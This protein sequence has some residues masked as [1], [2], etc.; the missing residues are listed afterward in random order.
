MADS[1][2]SSAGGAVTPFMAQYLAAKADHPDALLFF[3][4]GDFYEMFFEDARK[5]AAALSITLTKRGQHN[6]DDIPMAG[7]PVHAA[8]GYLA[9]L[10]RAGFRV[11]VCEQLE[12]PAEA[13]KRGG[14]AIVKRAVVRVVTPGTVTED[15]LLDARRANCLAAAIINDGEAALAWAEVS[16]GAFCVL[17]TSAARIEEEIA[18]LGPAELLCVDT[19]AQRFGDVASAVTP[20]PRV[21]A[22]S[23]S[24]ERRLKGLFEVRTLEAFGEFAPIEL[25]ALGLILDYVELTQAGL[26]PRLEPPR[27]FAAQAY[28]AIDPATR[29]SLEI[30]RTQRGEREGSLIAAIDRT[31]SAAG[32]R[33]LAQ[34]LARPLMDGAA[35]GQRLDAVEYFLTNPD[36]RGAVRAGLKGAADI[37]RALQRL[38]LGR[39]GP[40]DLGALRDGLVA[41]ERAAVRC[42]PIGGP[43]PESVAQ[44][45]AALTLPNH[46]GLSGLVADLSRALGPELGLF[47]RDGGFIAAG[48]DPGL[49]N[50]RALRD[51]SRRVIVDLQTKYQEETA[52][53]GLKIRHNAVLGYHIDATAKQAEVLM[54]PPLSTTFIHRQT[55]ASSIRFTTT[56]LAELDA[57]IS[58]AAG[59]ALA[60]EL[61][62]FKSFVERVAALEALIRAAAN[63]LAT[64]DVECASAEW[65]DEQNATRPEI[66]QSAAFIC[67]A[68]RHPVV[69]AALM[70]E[71]KSFTANDARLDGDGQAG[72]RLV[73]VTGPNM[74]GKSTYLRQ[75]ALLAIL[76]QTGFFV[77][78]K[79][80]RLGLADRVFSRVGAADDLARGRSTFMV[81]MV[82]TAAILNQATDRSFVV[83]DEIGRGTATF[84]GLS[85]AWATL[86]Y[87]HEVNRSRVLFAT[88][89]HELTALADRLSHAANATVEV[90]EW[91]DEIVFLY[92]VVPG[93]ADRSYGIHVAKLAGLPGP[94]LARAGEVL[95]ELDRQ[96]GLN[97][98]VLRTKVIRHGK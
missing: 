96:L 92:R 89:Y 28:M 21:K 32:G 67:E 2:A 33:M 80:L 5:A 65:A 49:E 29:A 82:E 73:F 77:P 31:I 75:I 59:E 63:A 17:A 66:D 81:E 26:A 46:A 27:R 22:D 38:V 1:A 4:M 91:K 11:A 83:L 50:V 35:I 97:E 79:R 87:L 60:R 25:S 15:S 3:R 88:H 98:S 45:C 54:R 42:G 76:A 53:T 68:G 8:D 64:L 90:K 62:L 6:G 70:R 39:G 58:R 74:A 24:A 55:L 85:I 34:R 86:E 19:Q 52:L 72:P 69:E 36:V 10:I 40:R 94:V 16:T 30:E 61:E 95:K 48:F 13:R 43:L 71:G 93:A 51:D 37:A 12:D 78:A 56:E 14:K 7:V 18:A 9:K 23:R 44:A 84:D 47:A 41:G 57:R 20:R